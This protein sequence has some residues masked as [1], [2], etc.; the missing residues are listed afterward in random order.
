MR[1]KNDIKA[2][3]CINSKKMGICYRLKIMTV[4]SSVLKRDLTF[5]FLLQ[6]LIC[7]TVFC[8]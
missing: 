1:N 5:F 6:I 7:H 4:E 8:F 2:T 3:V